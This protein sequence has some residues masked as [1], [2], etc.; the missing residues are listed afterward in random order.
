MSKMPNPVDAYIAA[1]P[2]ETQAK[3]R[4]MRAIIRSIAP[5]A[6]E[7]ISYGMPG[8]DKGRV[9]WFSARK[10]YIGLYLRPPI[11]AEHAKELAEYKTTKSAIHLPLSQPLP[12]TLIRK[13]IKARIKKNN[14][15]ADY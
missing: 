15:K 2:K 8:Y 6:V 14:P 12:I 5:S 10:E 9:A 1:A 11:I 13:L 4:E 3:L 7:N